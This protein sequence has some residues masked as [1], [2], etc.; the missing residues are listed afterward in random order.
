M[1]RPQQASAKTALS[2]F[3]LPPCVAPGQAHNA[4]MAIRPLAFAAALVLLA[5]CSGNGMVGTVI[6]EIPSPDGT[7]VATLTRDGDTYRIYLSGKTPE[8][9]PWEM[10]R[11]VQPRDPHLSWKTDTLAMLDGCGGTFDYPHSSSTRYPHPDA[12]HG[13]LVGISNTG[14]R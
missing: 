1:V 12:D 14:C 2:S 10:V 13:I 7:A 4:G 9:A 8:L 11:T 5:S 3:S 6:A